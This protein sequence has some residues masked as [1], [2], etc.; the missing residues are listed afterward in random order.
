[1]RNRH[2]LRTR[3][4]PEQATGPKTQTAGS[5]GEENE[6]RI[7]RQMAPFDEDT[8]DMGDGNQTKDRSGGDEIGFH[9]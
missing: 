1:M 2:V 3:R 8:P 7:S 5:K 9:G 4:V 6:H